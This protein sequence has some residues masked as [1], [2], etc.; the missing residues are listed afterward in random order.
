MCV[1]CR[2]LGW[3]TGQMSKSEAWTWKSWKI[4]QL[5]YWAILQSSLDSHTKAP[6]VLQLFLF[7]NN[8]LFCKKI[9]PF[10]ISF[11]VSVSISKKNS[12][13]DFICVWLCRHMCGHVYVGTHVCRCMYK[14]I[15]MLVWGFVLQKL[16]LSA[17][18]SGCDPGLTDA[19]VPTHRW[20][21]DNL[22]AS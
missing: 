22:S 12:G 10:K 5:K 17:R 15:Y 9:K 19:T 20:D 1:E 18:V 11:N 6:C 21:L 8:H 13:N 14:C 7:L 4:W 16:L 3:S 2:Y